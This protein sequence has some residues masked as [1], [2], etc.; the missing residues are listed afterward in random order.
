[1]LR[2]NPP[3]AAR[4]RR[5]AL[6]LLGAL[7]LCAFTIRQEFLDSSLIRGLELSPC[8]I[9][10]T[11][12]ADL[13]LKEWDDTYHRT[14]DAVVTEFFAEESGK[15]FSLDCSALD[16]GDGAA[17]AGADSALSILAKQL[18]PWSNGERTV[19]RLSTTDVLRTYLDAYAC[20]LREA[21]NSLFL[22]ADGESGTEGNDGDSPV[23][24][25]EDDPTLV[26]IDR[27]QL[28]R[29]MTTDGS[30]IDRELAVSE[31]ALERVLTLMAS[32]QRTAGLKTQLRCL[33][34]A[35]ADLRNAMGLF[36]QASAC[37][38]RLWDTKAIFRDAPRATNE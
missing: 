17:V 35:S 16:E 30:T 10:G 37:M 12:F 34:G 15:D 31:E 36:S 28:T 13:P 26:S 27:G 1:M 22:E 7:G 20:S 4:K 21:R 3:P 14:V 38:G 29:W 24:V 25:W 2:K 5:L 33:L 6:G 11:P 19:T 9:E 8:S 32:D 18:P 23:D